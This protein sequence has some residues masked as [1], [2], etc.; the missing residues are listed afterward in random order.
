MLDA[1]W[2]ANDHTAVEVNASPVCGE[3]FC[4][5]CGDC[6]AC[7]WEDPCAGNEY[8][9]WHTWYVPAEDAA[10]WWANHP[11]AKEIADNSGGT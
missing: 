9:P 10:E 11:D 8:A 4:E 5:T 2:V 1:A 6:L 7:H 3:D